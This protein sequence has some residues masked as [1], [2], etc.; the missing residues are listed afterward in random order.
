MLLCHHHHRYSSR[1]A[2]L[3]SFTGHIDPVARA[4]AAKLLAMAAAGLGPAEAEQQL[5]A[6][7]A[8]FAS[9]GAGGKGSAGRYEEVEGAV[10]AT[11]GWQLA[12]W[13]PALQARLAVS[14]KCA[15]MAVCSWAC[16]R[17]V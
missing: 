11:G 13:L 8:A 15:C 5:Q 4:V 14:G 7:L 16:V 6:L 3:A 2:W 1:T 12:G 17:H 10:L 9:G